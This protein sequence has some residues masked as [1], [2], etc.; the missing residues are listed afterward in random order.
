MIASFLLPKSEPGAIAGR[1]GNCASGAVHLL[2]PKSV[3]LEYGTTN[4]T[5]GSFASLADST[6]VHA[7]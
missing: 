5:T 6:R 7:L 2:S 1:H 3:R 4:L